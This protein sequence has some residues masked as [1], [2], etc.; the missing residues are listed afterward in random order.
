MAAVVDQHDVP[1]LRLAGGG[2]ADD[3]ADVA[4]HGAGGGEIHFDV[5]GVF[6]VECFAETLRAFGSQSGR[7]IK[8]EDALF[9]RAGDEIVDRARS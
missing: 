7:S 3:L 4:R 6:L 5:Q 1:F 9:F 8:L 2:D